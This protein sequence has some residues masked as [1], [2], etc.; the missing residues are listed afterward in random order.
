MGKKGYIW[1]PDD[2]PPLSA[3]SIAKHRILREYVQTY[4]EVLCAFHGKES[5]NVSLVDGFAGG[6]VYKNSVDSSIVHGSPLILMD[7]VKAAEEKINS[8]RTVQLKV[9]AQYFFVD[10]DIKATNCLRYLISQRIDVDKNMPPQIID[11]TFE[12]SL[13]NIIT[14]IQARKGK[15]RSIFVLDQ[16]GYTGV[17][18]DL[19]TKI[20]GKLENAEIFL[21]L[22]VGWITSYL[23]TAADAVKK[24][25]IPESVFKELIR[26]S[27][28][29]I[30]FSDPN[31]R[32]TLLVIQQI[33]NYTF[34]KGL[35]SSK[36]Y[37]PFFIMSRDSNRPYWFLHLANN[38]KAHD[39]VK[40]L[41]WKIENHFNHFGKAGTGML[42][43]DPKQD[44]DYITQQKF[45]F[46]EDAKT[47]TTKAL[48]TELPR[49]FSER[50]SSGISFGDLYKSI[51]NETPA[52]KKILQDAVST[53]CSEGE[54]QKVGV[55]D[56]Q[57]A[58]KT[59]PKDDDVISIPAQKSFIFS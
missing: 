35:N 42:G 17:P 5:F 18:L 46:D 38:D 24:L 59:P 14:A 22:A 50:F 20:F 31:Q 55:N 44:P 28:D 8:T 15:G 2:P 49:T 45:F 4:I 6:G 39:V 32:P 11:S 29:D 10:N 30:D 56:E 3:H 13:D 19:I 16:Y 52:D 54:L 12:N 51:C 26:K 1:S 43:Y 34:T 48:L 36:Y 23:K 25:G 41:H 37:T 9:N 57:R 40:A 33:L 21:T 27:E 53:L 58:H 7:A 47:Q